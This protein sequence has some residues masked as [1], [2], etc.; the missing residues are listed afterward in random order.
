MEETLKKSTLKMTYDPGNK[1]L[2]E[3]IKIKNQE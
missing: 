3:L 2:K 1:K